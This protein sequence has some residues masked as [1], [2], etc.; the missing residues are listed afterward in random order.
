MSDTAEN[1]KVADE[2]IIVSQP[3]R[4]LNHAFSGITESSKVAVRVNKQT[5]DI[6]YEPTKVW[7]KNTATATLLGAAAAAIWYRRKRLRDV[8]GLVSLA[9][10]SRPVLS[11]IAWTTA[12]CGL[13]NA[14]PLKR[15]SSDAAGS[16]S[17][18]VW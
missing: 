1:G 18:A 15:K 2:Y 12:I 7:V 3:L 8:N 5:M 17:E 14:R 9:G 4:L 11:G 6:D 10:A 13:L 16:S